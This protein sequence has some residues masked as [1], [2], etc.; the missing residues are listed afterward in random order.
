MLEDVENA[1]G[2]GTPTRSPL[3]WWVS[4]GLVLVL[5]ISRS[6]GAVSM[7]VGVAFAGFAWVAAFD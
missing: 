3:W 1:T 4:G 6:I 5:W 2:P 7:G